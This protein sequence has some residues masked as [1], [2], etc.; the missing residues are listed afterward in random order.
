MTKTYKTKVKKISKKGKTELNE[1][2]SK[3][4]QQSE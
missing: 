3:Q 2:K 1:T 4:K